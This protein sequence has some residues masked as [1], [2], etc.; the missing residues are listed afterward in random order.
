MGES[1]KAAPPPLDAQVE[2]RSLPMSVGILSGL[3][4]LPFSALTGHWIGTFHTFARTALVL[5]AHYAFP[6]ARFVA[7]PAVIVGVYLVTIVVLERRY[8]ALPPRPIA[9]SAGREHPA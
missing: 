8:R 1:A 7:I 9:A 3:M 4:W 5:V 2:P 6:D